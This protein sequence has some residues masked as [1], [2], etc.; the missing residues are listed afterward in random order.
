MEAALQ[1]LLNKIAIVQDLQTAFALAEKFPEF[2]YTTLN[3]DVIDSS[4]LIEGGAAPRLDETLFGRRQLLEDLKIQ[5]PKR[6]TVLR[7]LKDRMDA[8]ESR[9]SSIDMKV[10]ADR[11]RILIND[12][13]NIEK[14]IAQFEFEKKKSAR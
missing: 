3:G 12:L 4:G 11:S 8:I 13:A 9:I 1:R 5:Y 6:E 10:L 2:T 7:E 14:Q